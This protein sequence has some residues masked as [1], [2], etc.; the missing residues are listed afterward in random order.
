MPENDNEMLDNVAYEYSVEETEAIEQALSDIMDSV[1]DY[2]LHYHDSTVK[3]DYEVTNGVDCC[4]E[5]I[6]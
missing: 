4:A 1:K 5:E 3:N 2:P 6:V